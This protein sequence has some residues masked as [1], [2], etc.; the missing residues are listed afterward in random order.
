MTPLK[1]VCVLVS[2]VGI[3]RSPEIDV[4]IVV[5]AGGCLL[6]LITP[7]HVSCLDDDDDEQL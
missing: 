1:L 5:F 3:H 7:P 2:F 6:T 4:C